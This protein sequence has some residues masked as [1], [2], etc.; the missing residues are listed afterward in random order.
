MLSQQVPSVT[1]ESRL[2][3]GSAPC[4]RHP[5]R[6]DRDLGRASALT[7]A[8]CARCWGR[9]A[10]RAA[11]PKRRSRRRGRG[12]AHWDRGCGVRAASAS[13]FAVEP[14]IVGRRGLVVASFSC[15]FRPKLLS[16]SSSSSR[17]KAK[18]SFLAHHLTTVGTNG[19]TSSSPRPQSAVPKLKVT[20]LPHDVVTRRLP[21][22]PSISRSHTES[23][24]S[25]LPPDKSAGR[26]ARAATR[27]PGGTACAAPRAGRSSCASPRCT[28]CWHAG[29]RSFASTGSDKPVHNRVGDAATVERRRRGISIASRR[30]PHVPVAADG[31]FRE[32]G[33]VRRRRAPGGEAALFSCCEQLPGDKRGVCR[34][35]RC[36][37]DGHAA[38]ENSDE[39]DAGYSGRRGEC[40]ASVDPRR[41]W[42]PPSERLRNCRQIF[43]RKRGLKSVALQSSHR[44]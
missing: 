3:L 35:A 40:R 17:T 10:S 44:V 15:A 8:R 32:G 7:R 16:P 28:A 27:R 37:A 36:G 33:E 31:R 20:P 22:L 21:G 26:R 38:A 6:R 18:T 23:T 24:S 39:Q 12:S 14:S 13:R 5:R 25:K 19:S 2:T 4:V 41:C 30:W 11:A 42:A 9:R 43:V 34:S 1:E 29:D